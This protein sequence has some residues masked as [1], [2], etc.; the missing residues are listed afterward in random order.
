M[1]FRSPFPDL[2]VPDVTLTDF[3][4]RAGT[5][6]PERIALVDGVSGRALTYGALIE[7]VRRLAAG[8]SRRGIRKGDIVAIWAPNLPEYAV[9]FH[10]VARLGA[11]L[12]TANPAY[13]PEELAC[14]L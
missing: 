8:L 9:V 4:L 3:V 1:L 6:Y 13:T 2:C 12:T 7:Q 5:E 14:Q 11:I 10:A